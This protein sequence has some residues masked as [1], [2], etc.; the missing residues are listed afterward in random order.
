MT[1][2]DEHDMD[3]PKNWAFKTKWG[4]T[5]IVSVFTFI[6]PTSSAMSAPAL[7][8]IGRDLN[9]SDSTVLALLISIF[10]LAYAIGPLFLGTLHSIARP[11]TSPKSLTSPGP[12]SEIYG[13]RVVLQLAN[14]FFLA[15]N[16]GCGFATT[17]GQLIAFRFLSGL[18]GSAPLAIGGGILSDCW[19]AEQRG[20]AVGLYSLMPLLGPAVGPVAGGWIAE[21]TTWRWCFWSTSILTVIIQCFGVVYLRETYA[22][23]ILGRRAQRMRRETGDE[24]YHT[25]WETPDRTLAKVLKTSLGR[26]FRLLGTQVIIQVLALYMAFIYGLMYLVL[27]TYPN[28]WE[29]VYGQSVGIGGLNYISLGIGFFVG[30]QTVARMNDYLYRR[31]KEKNGGKGRPEFRAPM[32]LPGAILVPAG[33]FMYGWGAE[34]STIYSRSSLTSRILTLTISTGSRPLD[35]PQ[36]W[37]GALRRRHNR[38]LPVYTDLYRRQ[39]FD[40]R[41]LRCGVC[42]R[43]AVAGGIWVSALRKSHV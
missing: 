32:I 24:R 25:E 43:A 19:T 7:P 13:R 15:W 6:S 16:I 35:R 21:K 33:I 30:A 34:V 23:V 4:A 28:V 39:L 26:P 8:Q 27:T 14:L 38:Q 10:V 29:G 41:R 40:I 31:L 37:R 1:W 5:A 22:P 11:P 12:L 42:D 3:N 20:Q 17:S 36:H 2:N 9:V 18:G